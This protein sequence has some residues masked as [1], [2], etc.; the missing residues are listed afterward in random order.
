MQVVHDNRLIIFSVAINDQSRA[1]KSTSS[2]IAQPHHEGL[3]GKATIKVFCG[4]ASV[5]A[6]GVKAV[7]LK[8]LLSVS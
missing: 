5:R 1:P 3:G 7:A 4:C 2:L 6:E 8:L